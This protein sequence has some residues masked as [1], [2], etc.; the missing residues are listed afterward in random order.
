VPGGGTVLMEKVFDI[1]TARSEVVSGQFASFEL[2]RDLP[3][4]PVLSETLLLME[5]VVK[6]W[7]VDLTRVARVILSDPGAALQVMRRAGRE[8][9]VD[10]PMDRIEDCISGIGLQACL[11]AM[12]R[13]TITRSSRNQAVIHAWDHA[14]AIAEISGVI[15]EKTAPDGTREEAEMVGLCHEIG[16]FA[17]LLGWDWSGKSANNDLAGLT[18]AEA[19]SLPSCVVEYFSDRCRAGQYSRWTTIVDRAHQIA[20]NSAVPMHASQIVFQ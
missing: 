8:Y 3:D 14:R 19:W 9:D 7:V 6:N 16:S 18:L 1:R 2:I 13:R 5:M 10:G 4:V 20:G 15:A 12:S 11:D 17:E